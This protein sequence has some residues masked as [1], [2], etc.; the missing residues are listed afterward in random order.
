MNHLDID[1]IL[2]YVT[3]I[4]LTDVQKRPGTIKIDF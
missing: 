1:Y 4:L 3:H 2:Y